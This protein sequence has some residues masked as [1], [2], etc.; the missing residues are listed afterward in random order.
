MILIIC[1]VILVAGGLL[2]KFKLAP[3]DLSEVRAKIQAWV[4]SDK[5]KEDIEEEE[6]E[7]EPKE[8]VEEE[9]VATPEKKTL[10]LVLSDTITIKAEYEEKD[11]KKQFL[12]IEPYEGVTFDISP[13]KE[14]ILLVDDKQN[15][16]V[17]NFNNEVKDATKY[18]YISTAGQSFPKES[19]LTTTP[20]YIWSEQV[21]FISED[22]IIFVSQLPFFGATATSKYVWVKSIADGSEQVLWNLKGTEVSVGE[23]VQDKGI[24]ISIDGN[25]AFYINSDGAVVQ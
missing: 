5:P 1:L 14:E 20:E 17:F 23:M 2:I 6:V 25:N 7:E 9:I 15:I 22:K 3:I 11:G 18:E 16:K 19:I 24:N 10:D 13:S 8:E 21:R 12:N 4:D